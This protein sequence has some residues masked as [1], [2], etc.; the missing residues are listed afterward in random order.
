M[1][2][3]AKSRLPPASLAL[4]WEA[5]VAHGGGS[6][7]SCATGGSPVFQCVVHRPWPAFVRILVASQI[8]VTVGLLPASLR[9]FSASASSCHGQAHV[10]NSSLLVYLCFG[11]GLPDTGFHVPKTCSVI[12]LLSSVFVSLCD[13]LL[14]RLLFRSFESLDRF[15]V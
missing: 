1:A 2:P 10:I 5:A 8:S 3:R 11:P 7:K 6:R 9:A 4:F 13:Q 12:F 15:H 14:W